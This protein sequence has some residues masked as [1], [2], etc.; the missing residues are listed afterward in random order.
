MTTTAGEKR[1]IRRSRARDTSKR[2]VE[3]G[4]E[5]VEDLRAIADVLAVIH[6]R[7]EIFERMLPADIRGMIYGALGR[8]NVKLVLDTPTSTSKDAEKRKAMTARMY[9]NVNAEQV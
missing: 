6:G 5:L 3:A 7:P 2:L 9:R 4:A 8:E 1:S